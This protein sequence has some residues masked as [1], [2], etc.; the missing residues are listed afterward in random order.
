MQTEK[1]FLKPPSLRYL[2]FIGQAMSWAV[3]YDTQMGQYVALCPVCH[4]KVTYATAEALHRELKS[5]VNPGCQ[6]CRA[7]RSF[8]QN[9][10]LIGLF[11]DFWYRTGTFPQNPTWLEAIPSPQFNLWGREIRTYLEAERE[12][13]K[14]AAFP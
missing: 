11:L 8:E 9:P 6:G 4:Q 3:W 12:K 10:G 13:E 7:K 5:G 2:P 1:N 14:A